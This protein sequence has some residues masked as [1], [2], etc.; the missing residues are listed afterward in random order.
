MRV[1]FMK[2]DE[3]VMGWNGQDDLPRRGEQ[4]YARSIACAEK[5]VAHRVTDVAWLGASLVRMYIEEID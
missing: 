5:N 2:N 4:V 3:I 1:Q